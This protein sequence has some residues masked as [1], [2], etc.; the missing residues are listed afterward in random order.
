MEEINNTSAP[1]NKYSI[2]TNAMNFGAMIALTLIAIS[3]IL[4]F[5]NLY[6]AFLSLL[7]LYSQ[8]VM[9]LLLRWA[10]LIT[11]MVLG[12]LYFRNKILNG[13]IT[14]G[15]ALVAGT[16]IGVFFSIIMSFY[17][18]VFIKYVEPNTITYIIVKMDQDLKAS[19]IMA[20]EKIDEIVREAK[21]ST[22][23]ES[24]LYGMFINSSA[25]CFIF[26]LITSV[27]VRKR[28]RLEDVFE[29]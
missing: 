4:Y 11:G 19:G 27:F 13:A 29:K 3:L 18:Y 21:E 10:V 1:Q 28:E 26:A 16:L 17:V 8:P 7:K 20:S 5:A 22:T 9:L 25:G 2:V 12:S 15:K 24:Y 23:A 6:D 14:Y